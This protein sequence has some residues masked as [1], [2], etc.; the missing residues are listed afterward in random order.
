LSLNTR[1]LQKNQGIRPFHLAP[2]APEKIKS[3]PKV[4]GYAH[5]LTQKN[6]K[7]LLLFL[8][9][10][11]FGLDVAYEEPQKVPTTGIFHPKSDRHIQ[12]L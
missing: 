9:N 11:D 10:R 4:K 12:Y 3:D 8:L 1:M 7:N 6:L 5:P 2:Q